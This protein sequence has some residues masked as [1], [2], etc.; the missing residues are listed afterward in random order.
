MVPG[1]LTETSPALLD[2]PPRPAPFIRVDRIRVSYA[3]KN[4]ARKTVLDG[5]DLDIPAG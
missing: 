5:I 3:L 4:G 1:S 2:L